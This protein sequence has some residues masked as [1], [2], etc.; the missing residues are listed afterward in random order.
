MESFKL[1]NPFISKKEA[2]LAAA[3]GYFDLAYRYSREKPFLLII[4]GLVGT[5]KTTVAQVLN[6]SLGFTVISSDITRKKLA[7]IAPTEHRFEEF[8]GGIYS[9][10]FS[11]K[12]YDEMLAQAKKL[13]SQRNSVIIDASFKKKEERERAKSLAEE[14]NANFIVIEC[15]LDEKTI[16]IRLEQRLKQGSISD[17]NWEIYQSQ[18]QDFDKI[19]EFQPENHIIVNTSQPVSNIL[20]VILERI[21]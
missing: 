17:G 7:G 3:R 11:H 2:A 18:K 1:D 14:V 12:T 8:S 16:K 15:V 9:A 5:G 21:C 10:D 20:R 19:M 4:T 13:L 6:Q